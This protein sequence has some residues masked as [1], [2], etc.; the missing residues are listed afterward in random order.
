MVTDGKTLGIAALLAASLLVGASAH[1]QQVTPA[2]EDH[3]P[4]TDAS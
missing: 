4:V 1:A 2:D 3:Q